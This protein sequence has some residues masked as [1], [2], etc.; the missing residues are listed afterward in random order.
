MG[1]NP[2]FRV[3]S[4]PVRAAV[5]LIATTAAALLAVVYLYDPTQHTFYPRCA[6]YELTGWQC[7]GGGAP[8][9]LH[10]LLHGRLL[11]AVEFTPLAVL[12]LG[13]MPVVALAY[14]V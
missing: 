5:V 11:R 10:A 13:G 6:L 7:P 8:R 2:Q 4:M 1:S 9:A 12:A 14:R 3:G